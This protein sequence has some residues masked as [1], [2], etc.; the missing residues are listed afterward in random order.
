MDTYSLVDAMRLGLAREWVEPF[1]Q[2]LLDL[3]P[4][5]DIEF[6]SYTMSSV[7]TR[8]VVERMRALAEGGF[9]FIIG[10]HPVPKRTVYGCP[11]QDAVKVTQTSHRLHG[12][13]I[14][15]IWAIR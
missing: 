15:T 7:V 3:E 1:R 13:S 8:P 10:N 4:E 12:R 9:R 2:S 14:R 5:L 11:V 6:R